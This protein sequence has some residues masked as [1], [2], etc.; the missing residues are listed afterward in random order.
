MQGRAC[1]FV[2]TILNHPA[3]GTAGGWAT[4]ALGPDTLRRSIGISFIVMAGWMLIPDRIAEKPSMR[5]AHGIAAAIF[6][7]PG[8]PALLKV[9]KPF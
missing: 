5:A 6:G 3:A 2:A 7:V 8:A 1:T 4:Q 9:G